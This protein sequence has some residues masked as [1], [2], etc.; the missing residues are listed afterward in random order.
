MR[1]SLRDLTQLIDLLVKIKQC[2]VHLLPK[3]LLFPLGFP[4]CFLSEHNFRLISL[5]TVFLLNGI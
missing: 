1:V 2:S 3:F 4:L 5:R